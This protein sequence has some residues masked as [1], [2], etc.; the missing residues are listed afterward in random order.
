MLAINRNE[1]KN[2]PLKKATKAFEKQYIS[3]VLES[4][5]GNRGKAAEILGIHRNTL[6][7]KLDDLNYE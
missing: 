1:I 2:M 3:S 5:S 4:V 7:A 6:T